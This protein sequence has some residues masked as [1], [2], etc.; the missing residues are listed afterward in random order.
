[1]GPIIVS[2]AFNIPLIL[3]C[4]SIKN[5]TVEQKRAV[6]FKFVDIVHDENF[7]Q[8]LTAKVIWRKKEIFR[9]FQA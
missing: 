7:P 9:H 1:M 8:D 3:M 5:Y 2:D 6:F 4:F